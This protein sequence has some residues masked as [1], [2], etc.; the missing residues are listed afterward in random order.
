MPLIWCKKIF[1]APLTGAIARKAGRGCIGHA[2][3]RVTHE[4]KSL[5]AHAGISEM[6]ALLQVFQ[7]QGDAASSLCYELKGKGC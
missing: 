6:K 5:R 7:L 3:P 4:E 1:L 2:L